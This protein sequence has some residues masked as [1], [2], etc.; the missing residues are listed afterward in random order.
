MK[1]C[2]RL[3]QSKYVFYKCSVVSEDFTLAKLNTVWVN[4]GRCKFLV[5][6]TQSYTG[7]S[8]V[9]L[10]NRTGT[11][12]VSFVLRSSN[13]YVPVC[14][15]PGNRK[16]S[17]YHPP[18]TLRIPLFRFPQVPPETTLTVRHWQITPLNTDRPRRVSLQTASLHNRLGATGYR[19]V[20]RRW[21]ITRLV[22]NFPEGMLPS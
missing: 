4:W 19:V 11:I 9:V 10:F 22:G 6:R 21:R 5:L 2:F 16:F 12:V 1:S 20:W 7:S 15:Y 3:F 8:S 18:F 13:G 14:S 17:F